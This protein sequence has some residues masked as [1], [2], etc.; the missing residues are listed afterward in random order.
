MIYSDD[1]VFLQNVRENVSLLFDPHSRA[2]GGARAP[3]TAESQQE[4]EECGTESSIY[5]KHTQ[6]QTLNSIIFESVL[7]A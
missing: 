1:L 4:E 3:I 6:T 5:R 2:A 7:E